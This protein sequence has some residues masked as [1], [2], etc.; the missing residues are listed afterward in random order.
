MILFCSLPWLLCLVITDCWIIP[1]L[2]FCHAITDLCLFDYSVYSKQAA[3]GSSLVWFSWADNRLSS[4][5]P[6]NCQ[7]KSPFWPPIN[8]NSTIWQHLRKSWWERLSPS[9][10]SP[11]DPTI[12]IPAGPFTDITT[13]KAN[14]DKYDGNPTKFR[15]LLM[16]Y[17]ETI[18]SISLLYCVS[19][20]LD[21]GLFILFMIVS[22]PAS[23]AWITVVCCLLWLFPA[24]WLLIAVLSLCYCSSMP[25]PTTCL[26]DYSVYS[27]KAANGSSPGWFWV[28]ITKEKEGLY[29]T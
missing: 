17:S 19:G 29:Y 5:F 22:L 11:S 6:P 23:S 21:L 7:P 26:F 2:L 27:N 20:L 12:P 4:R 10:S 25:L 14:Q 9:A 18:L 28:V 13:I 24:L 16:Q 3:N 15:W 8:N 1:V